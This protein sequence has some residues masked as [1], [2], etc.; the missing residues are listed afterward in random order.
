MAEMIPAVFDPANMQFRPMQAGDS[1]PI[2]PT[3]YASGTITRAAAASSGTEKITLPFRPTLVVFG[4]YD[5]GETGC[6]SNGWDDGA[7]RFA[8]FSNV[9]TVLA[10]IVSALR[11]SISSSILIQN[12][13]G[14]GH[15]GH[16]SAKHAD[17]FT[18]SWA[19]LGSGRD[20]TVKYY[21]IK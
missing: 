14:N 6:Y 15:S 9:L 17:G 21:A 4:G 7:E 19:R 12:F 18:I 10:A 5:N 13:L 3:G 20:I 11:A 8:S 2:Q 1:L 16:I